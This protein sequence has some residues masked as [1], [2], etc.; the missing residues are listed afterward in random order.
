[1]ILVVGATGQLGTAVVRRLEGQGRP[2]RAL[3]RRSSD[4]A[5]LSSPGVELCP[6][7]LRDLDRLRAACKGVSAVIATA[8][9]V[10]PRGRYSFDE[11]ESAG[12]RNL[13][14]ACR[15]CGVQQF[16]FTS[17]LELPERFSSRVPTLRFKGIIEKA[18]I[19]SGVSY[20]I[21]RAGPFMDDYF[22]L[23][24]SSIPLRN[25][26]AATLRRPF[27]LSR[28][29]LR[30][31]GRL[32]EDHGLALVPGNA[33]MRHSFIALEDVAH[34]LTR[35]IDHPE[36]RDRVYDIGGP[37][38]LS[39]QEVA[40][41]YG[42]VLDRPVRAR[43]LLPSWLLRAGVLALRRFSEAAANQLGILWALSENELVVDPEEATDAFDVRLSSAAE[44]LREKGLAP[45]RR[46]ATQAS[47]ASS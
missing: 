45:Q 34:Y 18:A 40:D 1:V 20:T 8:T 26:E 4:F 25:A 6:G 29:Y 2:V 24:G 21:F 46:R 39:W 3:V 19:E 42:T 44:F 35:A 43:A 5:H 17:I 9:V 31:V 37:E 27:W 22:A 41:L 7:D 33:G 23:M 12:Y 13:L 32:I 10:F 14:A 47:P 28:F 38:A 16:L 36:A 11:D 30:L 15:E